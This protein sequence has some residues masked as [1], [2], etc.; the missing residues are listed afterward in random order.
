MAAEAFQAL[1]GDVSGM[2]AKLRKSFLAPESTRSPL[3]GFVDFFGRRPDP[4][5]LLRETLDDARK[6]DPNDRTTERPNNRT[7]LTIKI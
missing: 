1:K 4:H 7:N 6:N 3:D 5:A 2:G